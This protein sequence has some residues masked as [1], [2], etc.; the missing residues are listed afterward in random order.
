MFG[1]GAKEVREAETEHGIRGKMF[2][3]RPLEL[4]HA[5]LG[6]LGANRAQRAGAPLELEESV[7]A[8]EHLGNIGG[9]RIGDARA[10]QSCPAG[11]ALGRADE[12]HGTPRRHAVVTRAV[13][14]VNRS[15]LRLD[16]EFAKKLD[17]F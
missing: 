3:E 17:K 8:R 10:E 12:L 16:A 1:D 6:R 15:H 7:H 4:F 9:Q 14:A 2:P 11:N 13:L 5:G